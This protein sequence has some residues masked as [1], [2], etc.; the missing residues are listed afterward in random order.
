[1]AYTPKE[2]MGNDDTD[3]AERLQDHGIILSTWKE[4]L[5]LLVYLPRNVLSN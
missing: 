2:L 1:M 3:D 4:S 5:L